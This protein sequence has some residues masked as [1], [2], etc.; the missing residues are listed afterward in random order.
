MEAPQHCPLCDIHDA[1]IHH[2]NDFGI[3]MYDDN[4]VSKGHILIIPRRHIS[5]FFEVNENERK[6]LISLLELARND[7]KIRFQPD[8]FHIGFNEGDIVGQKIEH[9]HI[10][11]IPR[12]SQKP[13]NLDSR[14]GIT[15]HMTAL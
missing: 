10:H 5:S 11:V 14:W 15:S 3:I 9:L 6:N 13:L 12:Y 7:L 2:Q 4:P 8:G 1:N